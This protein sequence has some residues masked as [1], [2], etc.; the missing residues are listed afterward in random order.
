M[1][2]FAVAVPTPGSATSC[3][4]VPVLR[5]TGPAAGAALAAALRVLAGA[6]GAAGAVGAAGAAGA[7]AEAPLTVTS[8]EILAIVLAETPARERSAAEP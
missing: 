1:I 3:A 5:S 4:S 7:P 6:A 2:F 8:G